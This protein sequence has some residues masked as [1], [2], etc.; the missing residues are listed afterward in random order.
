MIYIHD[1]VHNELDVYIYKV[2]SDYIMYAEICQ[3][4][5]TLNTV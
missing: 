3:E 1:D 2:L 4:F 5:Y